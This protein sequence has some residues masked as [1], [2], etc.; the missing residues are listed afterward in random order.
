MAGPTIVWATM[1]APVVTP[2]AADSWAK[3]TSCMTLP[4]RPYHSRG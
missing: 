2:N 1:N 4:P 3:I